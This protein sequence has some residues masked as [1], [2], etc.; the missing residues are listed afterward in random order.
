MKPPLFLALDLETKAQALDLVKKTKDYVQAYKIGPR[1]F[2]THGPPLIEEIKKLSSC[3]IFLDFKFYDIPSSTLE[4]IRSAFQ[5]GAD[6]A[7]IHASVGKKT[8]DLLYSF[9]QEAGRER[10]FKI[11]CVTVLS[12]EDNSLENQKRVLHLADQVYQSGLRGLV[13]S[14]WEV[15]TLKE[16]YP[17]LFLVTPGIRLEGDGSDDQKR[18][19]SPAQ[20]L[21]AGSSALVIGRSVT[22]AKEP[23][24]TL[25]SICDSIN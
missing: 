1:L 18:I 16:K 11:L 3:Q 6:F 25:K 23:V 8:L 2:L 21:S 24:K 13:C 10:F 22:K 12:S 9:E 14:P 7:T 20:A 4:A 17:E 5:V 15:K 19:M